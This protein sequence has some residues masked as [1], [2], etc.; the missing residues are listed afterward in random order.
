MEKIM[1]DINKILTRKRKDIIEKTLLLFE[2]EPY[3]VRWDRLFYDPFSKVLSVYGWIAKENKTYF[4]YL[5]LDFKF[6]LFNRVRVNVAGTSSAKYSSL[7]CKSIYGPKFSLHFPCIK[8][9]E[10]FN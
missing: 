1:K 8:V 9:K 2:Q 5:Q 6:L 10:Y 4:D 7:I 3:L